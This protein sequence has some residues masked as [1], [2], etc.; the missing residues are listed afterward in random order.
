VHLLADSHTWN[1][2]FLRN[3]GRLDGIFTTDQ[4]ITEEQAKSIAQRMREMIAGPANAGRVLV[5]G[6][7]FKYEAMSA[8]PKEVDFIESL[9]QHREEILG[10]F[11]V[12]P[13]L[14]GIEQGDIG[15]RTEQITN[16]YQQTIDEICSELA[17]TLQ[18][19]LVWR[20]GEALRIGFDVEGELARIADRLLLA[21]ID[22]IRLRTGQRTVNELRRRDGLEPVE[23]GET[24]WT[25]VSTI[26]VE[27][28][29]EI[30][31]GRG[32]ERG[33]NAGVAAPEGEGRPESSEDGAREPTPPQGER[34]LKALD[35]E[36]REKAWWKF[37]RLTEELETSFRAGLRRVFAAV[38]GAVEDDLRRGISPEGVITGAEVLTR[39][40]LEGLGHERFPSVLEAGWERG[41]DL[42]TQQLGER[43]LRLVWPT[44]KAALELV[45]DLAIPG[46]AAFLSSRPAEYA[47]TVAATIG[48]DL[49]Q[50]V[51]VLADQGAS[52]DTIARQ[53]VEELQTISV[54]RSRVIARTEVIG[55]ANRGALESY[56]ASGVVAQQEWLSARDERAR[57]SHLAA[58]GQETAL[59]GVFSVGGATLRY[60]GDPA[61]PPEETV[62]CRCTTLPV[63]R[64]R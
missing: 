6:Q 63:V 14:F 29:G 12:P 24:W 37:A 21:Q 4:R 41:I 53:L 56:R 39:Q 36:T 58:D 22:E 9:K 54:A 62:N 61:G 48:R 57:A 15:R 31:D 45:F 33:D 17:D 27:R 30:L 52:V 59:G 10:V 20:Y 11:G 46:I 26:P 43:A 1:R 34:G 28:A 51:A 3:A 44:R 50:V 2:S 7:G 19:F 5:T 25:Q 64:V 23:W 55:A 38:E 60:P 16:F 35:A 13:V 32:G 8:T 47:T 49:R 18:E 40:L 42:V